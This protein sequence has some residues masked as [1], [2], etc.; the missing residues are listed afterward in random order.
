[1][2]NDVDHWRIT[3]SAAQLTLFPRLSA[4]VCAILQQVQGPNSRAEAAVAL[5]LQAR[6]CEE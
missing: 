1:M 6:R 3:S 4:I 2:A 5:E